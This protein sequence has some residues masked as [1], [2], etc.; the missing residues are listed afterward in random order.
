MNRAKNNFDD[1]YQRVKHMHSIYL[2]LLNDVHFSH[3]HIS[4]I[5]RNEVVA[6]VSALDKFIHEIIRIGII[7]AYNDKRDIT[8]SFENFTLTMGELKRFM[9]AQEDSLKDHNSV[10]EGIIIKRHGHLSFQDPNKINE[11][12]ALIWNSNDR[13]KLIAEELNMDKNSFKTELSNIVIR[14]NQIVHEADIDLYTNE[15]QNIQPNDT[16]EIVEFI[17]NLVNSIYSLVSLNT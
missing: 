16:E 2:Y 14:R 17:N 15:I 8:K 3:E 10:L 6:I 1:S 7:E 12:L 5:L 4:D 9:D 13:L 11:A